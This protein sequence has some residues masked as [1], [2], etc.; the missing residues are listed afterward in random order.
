MS[1]KDIKVGDLVIRLLAGKVPHKLKVTAVDDDLIVCGAWTFD[2][3]T[4]VE[5]DDEL[6]WGRKHGISGSYLTR[7]PQ[8]AIV[9]KNTGE[10]Q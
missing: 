10:S 2:R 4:G 1:F 9:L 8:A 3:E 7:E 5:E 6:G